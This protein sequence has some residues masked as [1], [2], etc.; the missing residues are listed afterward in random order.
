MAKIPA[1]KTEPTS[2]EPDAAPPRVNPAG[3]PII[4]DPNGPVGYIWGPT[5]YVEN[6]ESNQTTRAKK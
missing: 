6:H 1:K 4:D 2:P 3:F 5:P